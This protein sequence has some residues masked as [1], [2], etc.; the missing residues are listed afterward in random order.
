MIMID[1]CLMQFEM[2]EKCCLSYEFWFCNEIYF[3]CGVIC[4]MKF[5]CLM[6]VVCLIYFDCLM[7]A[8]C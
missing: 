1:I 4:L 3:S 8:V 7:S 2:T 6:S 5:V